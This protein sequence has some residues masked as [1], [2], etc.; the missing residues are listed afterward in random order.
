MW[1]P[2]TEATAGLRRT[3]SGQQV[4]AVYVPLLDLGSRRTGP[5]NTR[6]G[7]P[8][9]PPPPSA[10]EVAEGRRIMAYAALA[11]STG[12]VTG[13]LVTLAILVV[14]LNMLFTGNGERFDVGAFLMRTS[15]YMWALLGTSL[16]CALSV[17]GAAWW[18]SSSCRPAC[19]AGSFSRHA[20][21]PVA[22]QLTAGQQQQASK[23]AGA[24][25]SPAAPSW[26]R[27][28]ARPASAPRT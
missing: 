18:V 23:Q 22:K 16:C 10:A 6:A 25:T 21:I 15:P 5:S 9:A 24:S 28:C 7:L 19:C 2:G 14:A 26:A 27:P 12:G 8:P 3:T 13:T 1:T 11:T 4:A 17:C 20:C